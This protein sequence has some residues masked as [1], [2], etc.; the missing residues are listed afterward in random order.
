MRASKIAPFIFF[1]LGLEF[2]RYK[3]YLLSSIIITKKLNFLSHLVNVLF[4][5][6]EHGFLLYS[7]MFLKNSV[8]NRT[9]GFGVFIQSGSRKIRYCK[10]CQISS[11]QVQQ[12]F[13]HYRTFNGNTCWFVER[14][15]R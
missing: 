15:A 2:Q 8:S 14:S 12:T 1:F 5:Y 9:C 13:F 10:A 11:Y 3:T 4:L 7:K 6:N